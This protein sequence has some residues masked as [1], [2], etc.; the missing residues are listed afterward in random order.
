MYWAT[1]VVAKLAVV[2]SRIKTVQKT[3][4]AGITA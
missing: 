4:T 2:C 3:I 1:N